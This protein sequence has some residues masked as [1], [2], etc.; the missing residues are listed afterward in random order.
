MISS[1]KLNL[2]KERIWRLHDDP[3]F[4][5]TLYV[6][7]GWLSDHID[8]SKYQTG[9]AV[10]LDS[11][12]PEVLSGF[13]FKKAESDVGYLN[14][15]LEYL[16]KF[17][18][19]NFMDI[20][21]AIDSYTLANL[22]AQHKIP[23]LNFTFKNN[24]IIDSILKESQGAI[25]WHHQ[26]ENL[27][28]FHRN[29]KEEAIEFR[30]DILKKRASVFDLASKIHID[31]NNTLENIINVRMVFGGTMMPS[32]KETSKLY[33]QMNNGLIE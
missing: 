16:R 2:I 31:Q 28:L 12:N 30:K 10:Y 27:Y 5:K 13:I 17:D 23:D 9:H 11:E 8:I 18:L 1:T 21:F 20:L 14:T 29:I 25:I 26:L 3:D 6:D 7:T 33:Y 32:L 15:F 19:T 4:T 24:S 22:F